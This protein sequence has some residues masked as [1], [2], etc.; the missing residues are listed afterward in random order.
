MLAQQYLQ[1][2]RRLG[3]ELQHMGKALHSFTRYADRLK[4]RPVTLELMAE[5]ARRDQG[6][7][8]DPRTWARRLKI[9]RPFMRWLQQF[10]PDTKVPDD[11]IFG[12]IGG[13]TAPHIYSE[14]ETGQLLRTAAQLAPALRGATYA[15]LFGLLLCTGLRVSEAI[16]LRNADV[17]LKTGVLTV[18]RTKFAKSRHV[19]LHPSALEALRRYRRLRAKWTTSSEESTFFVSCR[20]R[21]RGQPLTSRSVDR[22][23]QAVRTECH[24]PNRGTHHAPRV[25]DLRHTFAVRRIL[26]WQRESIDI[27]QAMLAL[28]TYLGHAMVTN[29]YWYLSGVP[30]LLG[31]AGQ[32]FESRMAPG[33]EGT[34]HV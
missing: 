14:E 32:R 15:T 13:R 9:L 11:T 12:P 22:V 30:E 27:D 26:A 6:R 5:W 8:T 34:S 24:W 28:S 16:R 33:A 3:F 25:H 21:L 17:D 18:R 1:E 23:L 10:E 19:P 20:G 4:G 2:R 31:L 7:S 29:T